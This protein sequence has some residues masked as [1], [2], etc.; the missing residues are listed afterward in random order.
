V[1]EKESFENVKYW[2]SEVDRLGN[3]DVNRI[4]VGN[5][6]DKKRV[7]T[8]EQGADL[9]KH[10]GMPFIE[11]SAKTAYNVDEVFDRLTKDIHEKLRKIEEE[12]TKKLMLKKGSSI[13]YSI[14]C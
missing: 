9:A 3:K 8:R 6:S 7:I 14:C 12:N 10:Y 5:K 1:S 4:L 11:T 13:A 2:M